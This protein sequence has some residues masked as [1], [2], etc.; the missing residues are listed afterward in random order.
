MP[1]TILSLKFVF[2]YKIFCFSLCSRNPKDEITARLKEM[3]DVFCRE[4]THVSVTHFCF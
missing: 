4:F 3:G 2:H 1:N